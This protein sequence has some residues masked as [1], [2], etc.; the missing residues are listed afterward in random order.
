MAP[1]SRN[2]NGQMPLHTAL[3]HGIFRTVALLLEFGADVDAQDYDNVT[4][5]LLVSHT[6]IL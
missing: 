4:P 1:A 3:D 6:T 5:L 2:K